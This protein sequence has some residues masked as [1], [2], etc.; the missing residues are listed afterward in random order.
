MKIKIISYYSDYGCDDYSDKWIMHGFTDWDEV[1]TEEY[2]LLVKWA[3]KRNSDQSVMKY[4]IY[5]Q[6][7]VDTQSRIQDYLDTIAAEERAAEEKRKKREA[8]KQ[9]KELAKKKLK[10]ADE[11]ALLEQLQKKYSKSKT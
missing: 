7:D 11:K 8:A 9:A 6:E 2:S 5:R 4:I 10:E 3:A 1:T